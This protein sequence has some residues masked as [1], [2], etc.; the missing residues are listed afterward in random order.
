MPRVKRQLRE[1]R[2]ELGEDHAEQLRTGFGFYPVAADFGP[3]PDLEDLREG[4]LELRDG[5][6]AAWVQEHPGSRPWAFWQFDSKEPRRRL[7]GVPPHDDPRRRAFV[8]TIAASLD[9]P[10][11]GQRY[12]ARTRELRFGVP[13]VWVYDIDGEAAARYETEVAY[14]RRMGLLGK[15]EAKALAATVT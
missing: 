15:E 1:R 5:I 3:D 8:A 10:E 12:I 4:W 6:M 7:D 13:S 14:L 2:P 9:S 11:E